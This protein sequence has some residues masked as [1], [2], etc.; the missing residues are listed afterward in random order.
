MESICKR[1]L[2]RFGEPLS[3]IRNRVS[4]TE[5]EATWEDLFID[6]AEAPTVEELAS[7][8]GSTPE[9][10]KAALPNWLI[11]DDEDR[12]VEKG[13]SSPSNRP[14]APD[15]SGVFYRGDLRMAEGKRKGM[16]KKGAKAWVKGTKKFSDKVE[17]A[18]RA[19]MDNPEGFAAWAQHKA[20]GKWPSSSND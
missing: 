1:L 17:K 9:A 8:L 2:E 4:P 20:T 5:I 12:V 18:K 19:G 3:E 10:V 6:N 11:V 16:T 13:M 15:K 14:A 7:W